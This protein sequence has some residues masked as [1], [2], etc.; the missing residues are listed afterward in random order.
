MKVLNPQIH[1]LIDYISVVGLALAPTLFGL[2]GISAILA[3]ALAVIHLIMTVLT[4]FPLGLIKLIPLKLHG[5]VEII[6]GASLVA[7]PWAFAGA[8]DF[9]SVG[10]IFYTGFGAVLIAVWLLSDY[11]TEARSARA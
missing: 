4:A 2:Q 5:L 7:L 10:R 1:G 8:L 9:G 6:V 11:G 3:Y